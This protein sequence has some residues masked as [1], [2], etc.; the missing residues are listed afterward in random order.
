MILTLKCKRTTVVTLSALAIMSNAK[1]QQVPT[2][3][4]APPATVE[5]KGTA[6]SARRDDTAAK[7]VIN[8]AEIVKYGDPSVL[9]VMKRLPGLTVIDS[10]VRMRGLG[11][12]YTQILVNGERPPAGFSLDSL[13]PDSVERI[14]IIRAATAEFST[15]SI[16]GTVNIVLK[17][18]VTK[19]SREVKSSVGAG[20]GTR[21]QQLN[22]ALSDKIDAFS[23]TLGASVLHENV[24]P[25]DV[26]SVDRRDAAGEQQAQYDTYYNSDNVFTSVN[27]NARLNWKLAGIDSVTWQTFITDG[28]ARG[29]GE[30]ATST[31]AGPPHPYPELDMSYFGNGTSVRSDVS[32]I[33]GIGA[34]GKL[35]TKF[36]A[37]LGNNKRGLYRT[38]RNDASDTVLDRNYLTDIQDTGLSWTGKLSMPWSQGHALGL[39]WDAGYNR[40]SEREIQDDGALPGTVPF[41]FDN[42]FD[43]GIARLALYAQD[44]WDV[45]PAWSIYLGVRGEA[46]R[47]RT[48]GADIPT[49]QS[50]LQVLSPLAQTLWK[51]PGSKGDQLRLALTRTFKAPELA[52]MVPR[53]FYTSLNTEISPDFTGNPQL[54]PELARGLDFA[55]E[56]YWAKG[57]M[58][59]ASVSAREIDGII[60]GEVTYNGS[61][62]VAVPQNLGTAH[63]RGFE[64]ESKFPLKAVMDTAAQIDLRASISRNWS[65]VDGVPGPDNRLNG[66]PR[67]SANVGADYVMGAWSG[68]ASLALV[69]GGWT[70]DAIYES[71]LRSAQRAL[72]AYAVYKFNPRSQLRFTMLNLL[73]T[74]T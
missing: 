1:A 18:S 55:Y 14:E 61:R 54:K 57:A 15:Q 32:W 48:S 65:W 35:D 22:L 52:R 10:S 72:E 45:S 16:A 31:F 29:T 2:S 39:G 38:A 46:I 6:D 42:S 69:A 28:R 11:N 19:A 7:I 70:R 37:S 73:G 44:E 3:N 21:A 33:A 59:S 40:R 34:T 50:H 36:G 25:K 23:Y 47:T 4:G 66:Q 5:I 27:L 56:H 74:G 24:L 17:R 43:A 20:P 60:R 51:I 30:Q 53:H 58:V 26:E 62:W 8:R 12:G 64:L 71:K 63:V 13:A 9:D 49:S 67:W 41:D 68:G